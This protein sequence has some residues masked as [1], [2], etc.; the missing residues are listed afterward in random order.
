[1]KQIVFPL[2]AAAL[3]SAWPSLAKPG[4]VPVA[5]PGVYLGLTDNW[6]Y[7]VA[8]EL[9]KDGTGTLRMRCL[10]TDD[11]PV[12]EYVFRWVHGGDNVILKDFRALQPKEGD[13]V[14]ANIVYEGA[15]CRV[16]PVGE[17]FNTPSVLYNEQMW[18][19]ASSMC[20]PATPAPVK[21]SGDTK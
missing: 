9:R 11:F 16:T 20:K 3:L 1:M 6:L 13:L 21:A 7:F 18:E 14:T 15:T 17:G 8:L 2:I 19:R 5:Q 12:R 4:E 10:P